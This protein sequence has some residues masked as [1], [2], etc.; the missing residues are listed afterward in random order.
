MVHQLDFQ[1]HIDT[2]DRDHL[3]RDVTLHTRLGALP[4]LPLLLSTPLLQRA[5]E[6]LLN[7]FDELMITAT[8]LRELTP[9]H[10]N[11][12]DP[13]SRQFYRSRFVKH[14]VYGVPVFH[15]DLKALGGS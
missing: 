8:T 5:P 12:I 4:N 9:S 10:S 2:L 3:E 13:V 15:I 7:G 6:D 1:L 14:F 11:D